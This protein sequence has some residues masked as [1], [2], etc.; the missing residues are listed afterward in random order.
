MV[1]S[2]G[3]ASRSAKLMMK[4]EKKIEKMPKQALVFCSAPCSFSASSCF[5]RVLFRLQNYVFL[6]FFSGAMCVG[7]VSIKQK[8]SH[9]D[10]QFVSTKQFLSFALILTFGHGEF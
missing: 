8:L 9:S 2:V 6:T 4:R 5:F 1:D 10:N 3:M 7:N